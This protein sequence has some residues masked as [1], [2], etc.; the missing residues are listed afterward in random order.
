MKRLMTIAALSLL[1]ALPTAKASA[2]GAIIETLEDLRDIPEPPGFRGA[3]PARIDL[4]STLPPPGNQGTTGSCTSWAATYGAGSQALRRAGQGPTLKLSPSFT[5]N[6]MAH[7]PICVTGTA[8]SATLD[9]LRDVGGL[10]FEKFV[11]DGG[12]CGRQPTDAELGEAAHYRIKG[13]TRFDARKIE[14]VKAQLARGVP[15]IYDM[16]PTDEFKK[17]KGDGVIDIPGVMNGVGHSMVAVGYDDARKAFRIQNSW[18]RTFADAG[19][20]WLGYDFWA[21]NTQVGY[22]IN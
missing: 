15:V 5:Y 2:Q 20:A 22:V 17:F 1:A 11:F 12:W 4:S 21:R 9:M 13:W 10:P 7:D 8:I 18:G 19:Y 16:R 14:E 6:K 3:L